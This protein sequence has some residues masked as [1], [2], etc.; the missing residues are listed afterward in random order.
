[1]GRR[2]WS[3]QRVSDQI[4]QAAIDAA[5]RAAF[6][7]DHDHL[8]RPKNADIPLADDEL[9]A[10][11]KILAAALPSLTDS[12]RKEVLGLEEAARS[13]LGQRINLATGA[14]LPDNPVV[15]GKLDALDAALATL[16]EGG[17]E[18]C[19]RC[20]GEKEIGEEIGGRGE[21]WG[22]C[23]DCTQ[24]VA[25]VTSTDGELYEPTTYSTA[26]IRSDDTMQDRPW[27]TFEDYERLYRSKRSTQ[28]PQQQDRGE[29]SDGKAT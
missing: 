28:P 14:Y 5:A 3:R 19:E 16:S 15:R 2:R 22:P 11:R 20:G 4:P 21:H 24:P 29:G 17:D 27:V 23:P 1:M 18:P 25:E 6:R 13:V 8:G 7:S 9:D 12:I 10:I 26:Q